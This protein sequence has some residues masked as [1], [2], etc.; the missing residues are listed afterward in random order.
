M[1]K[2]H[3]LFVYVNFSS[4]VKADFE[5]LSEFANVSKYEFK[6]G[7]GIISTGIKL[8]RQLLF[9]TT[10]FWRYDSVYIWF[11]DYHSL[12][13]VLFA[14]MSGKKSY[15][16]IG[17][18]EVARLKNLNYGALCS[19]LRAFFCVNSIKLSALNLTVSSYVDRKVKF[20][21]PGSKRQLVHNCIDLTVLPDLNAAKADVILTV[22]FIENQRSFYLKGIETFIEVARILP[23]YQFFIIGLDQFKISDLLTELPGNLTI[24]SWVPHSELPAYYQKSKFYCQLSRSESFG[25]S[26]AEAMYYGCMPIVTNEGGLP[27]VVGKAG[28]IVKRNPNDIAQLILNTPQILP[29]LK[30]D[31]S[32]RVMTDFSRKKRGKSIQRLFT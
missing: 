23:D 17:G 15:V 20:L 9:L 1:K 11:A 2:K 27:E 7:R 12:L 30:Q 4:F 3:I 19:G 14:R 21:A 6:I 22:G 18:Y 10:N 28:Y 25:V 24:L 29:E 16:V 5:I 31:L 26:V 32:N 8:F 13:P